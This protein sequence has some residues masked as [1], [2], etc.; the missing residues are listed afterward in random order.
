MIQ[1]NVGNE[2][3][4]G[5]WGTLPDGD[6]LD[7]AVA[8]WRSCPACERGVHKNRQF[9]ATFAIYL[10]QQFRAKEGLLERANAPELV[11]ERSENRCLVLRLREL[12]T[13]VDLGLDVT[14]DIRS[15]LREWQLHQT[16]RSAR[17]VAMDT[18]EH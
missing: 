11:R 5:C 12:M 3:L 9:L 10:V 15:F 2:P 4:P 7:L 14:G 17:S 8:S 18:F 16:R 6:P 1:A 13:R